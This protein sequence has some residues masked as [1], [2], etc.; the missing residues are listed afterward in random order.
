MATNM[1]STP[2]ALVP[3]GI[4]RLPPTVL[5]GGLALALIVWIARE[6]PEVATGFGFS[7][8]GLSN[9]SQVLAPAV[10][11]ALFIERSTEVVITSWRD[12]QLQ[13]LQHAADG[14][15]GVERVDAQQRVDFYRLETQRLA[16]M[17]SFSLALITAVVGFRV[18]QPL[19]DPEQAK[20][21][22][23]A[24]DHSQW[25]WFSRLDVLIT[26]LLIAGGADGIH[27]IVSTIT[28]FL[29]ST[30]DRAAGGASAGMTPQP[31]APVQQRA[32]AADA[33]AAPEAAA[34]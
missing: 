28:A 1:V 34:S 13:A 23:G 15:V 6:M 24:R 10:M 22:I 33:P 32:V 25:I 18:V 2:S 14:A 20:A 12:P 16:F 9:I 19:L 5:V 3:T 21:V 11:M 7:P 17:I 4:R 26:G 8:G 27:T 31:A 30:R 29:D